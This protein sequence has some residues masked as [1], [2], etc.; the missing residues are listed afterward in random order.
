[1]KKLFDDDRDVPIQEKL[2]LSKE[3]LSQ[4]RSEQFWFDNAEEMRNCIQH[5]DIH[6]RS[7]WDVIYIAILNLGLCKY[8]DSLFSAM[9]EWHQLFID[10]RFC[11][12]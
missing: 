10:K 3:L 6:M 4:L 7:V 5:K 8:W 11:Y 2:I 9:T 12:E 1:M